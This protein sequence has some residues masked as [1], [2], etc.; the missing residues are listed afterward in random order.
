MEANQL[1]VSIYDHGIGVPDSEIENI[2]KPFRRGVNVKYIGG[3]GI[4]LSIVAK[5]IEL[6][7]A[8]IKVSSTKTEGTCFEIKLNRET[9]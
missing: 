5:I 2:F 6:H 3:F 9:S 1:S 7:G 8:K 4:G